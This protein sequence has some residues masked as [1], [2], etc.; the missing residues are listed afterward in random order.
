MRTGLLAAIKTNVAGLKDFGV[1]NE[2]PWSQNGQEL[3]LKNLKKI[4]VDREHLEQSILIPVLDGNDVFQNDL[5]CEVYL[6][7]DA[8]NPPSQLDSVITQILASK[9]NTGL[10]NFGTEA[11]YTVDKNEDVLIYTFEFRVNQAIT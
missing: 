7:V 2:L 4:Y 10:V 1:S 5:I 11:D 8:K 9:N 3:Y 6:A